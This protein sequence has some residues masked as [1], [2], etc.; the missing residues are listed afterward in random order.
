M[1]ET[2]DLPTA[3]ES[4][5]VE[6]RW[7]EHWEK[8][9]Y[10]HAE[11]TS[12][13]PPFCI[14]IPPPNVTGSLHIGHALTVAV[15]DLLIRWKRM[16]GFNTL[17]MPGTDHAGIATQMVVERELLKT[18]KKSRQDLGREAFVERV[19]K[20]KAQYG[21]RITTQLRALGCSVDWPRERFTMDEGLSRAVREVFVQL[22]EQG[23]LYRA[24]RL[25]NWCP[26]DG[27]ALSDLEVEHEEQNGSLWHIAYPVEGTDRKLVV[28]T[29]RP[30]TMLGDTA[31][32]VHPDDPRYKDLIGKRVSLPLTDRKI[33][34]IADPILVDMNFGSGAV[35]VTPAHDPNDYETGLRHH[36][37]MISVLDER[38]HI[39][40]NGY[41]YKGLDRFKARDQI[42]ADLTAQ[43]LLEKVEPHKL[44]V[45]T[46][47]RCG[48]VIEP[49]LLGF[50]W[51]VKIKPLADK[52]IEAVE[53]GETN[54]VPEFWKNTFFAWM[55]NIHD[56]C[57]SRQIWWGH[58]I[59]AWYCPDGH[60]T[61][62]REEPKACKECGKSE[63][64]RDTDVLDT[65]FSSGLWPFSTLGW[66]DDTP[67]LR[68]F[69]PNSVM[70]T[71]HDII[72]FWV[73][74]MMM[75]GIHF[76]GKVPFKTVYLHAM[77]RDEK[78]DKMSKVK[79]NVVDPLDVIHGQK[80]ENLPPAI[81]KHYADKKQYPD[82]MP[83]YGADALRFTLVALTAQGRD[84]K[85]SLKQVEGYKAFANKI[86][87][88][89]RFALLNLGGYKPDGKA[90]HDRPLS[91]ADRW[92]LSR[93]ERA[94]EETLAALE[95]YKFN[96][97]ASKL[98]SFTWY[99]LCDWYIELS[100][101]A[102]SG[103]DQEARAAAQAVLVHC[104][105][106]TMKLLHPIMPYVTEEIWQKL[107]KPA[108]SP[109]S[110]MIAPYPKPDSRLTDRAAE[111]D[112]E[113][114]M[115]TIDGLRNIRGESNIAPAK[116]LRAVIYA[117]DH[118]RLARLQRHKSYVVSLAGLEEI[119]LSS[120]GVKPPKSAAYVGS[121]LEI[122]VPLEGLIDLAEEQK[123]LEKEIEK[124]DDDLNKLKT[125]H[126]NPNF[127]QRAPPE[128]IEKDRARIA[129]LGE[130]RSKLQANLQQLAGAST[131]APNATEVKMTT[132]KDGS[133][134][135][136]GQVSI[137]KPETPAPGEAVDLG[138]E[139]SAHVGDV[140]IPE[141]PKQVM[142]SLDKL[143]EGT[144]EGLS[145]QDHK[146]LGVAYMQM[147]LIDDAVREF[148]T[149]S[150]KADEE[151]VNLKS[152]TRPGN[153]P[154]AKGAK[155]P[156]SSA[157]TSKPKKSSAPK[158]AKSAKSSKST[159]PKSSKSA[160]GKKAPKAKAKSRASKP[161]KKKAG[162][163]R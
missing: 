10:F 161:V 132:N 114:V 63:L 147:G 159:K 11:D 152:S 146:D 80:L 98:H 74:R 48:T 101:G 144:K 136:E 79:G 130:K 13:K 25:I 39:N 103:S 163:K 22:Y 29:T 145:S 38:A 17:W 115:A 19:W 4:Q 73:A 68:T 88:A 83:A 9:G 61:V 85:L 76:M 123:R 120:S 46:C 124:V 69:Y 122:Y 53:R 153:T 52:A 50:Q 3:Y 116:K 14:V 151:T 30:E 28:A 45:G 82:G 60:V 140:A 135:G 8:A 27:T 158:S 118:E 77:V 70:E 36:L 84:I 66:P 16:S 104:L 2:I 97:A 72:F 35:K 110:I 44:A 113:P 157:R 150:A 49:M 138:K 99:E 107:P 81:Q 134:L 24:K 89:S 119:S 127:I 1:T 137:A 31:V 91:L 129:E 86:W 21:S 67:A 43:G 125:K 71:G 149:S 87:N 7:Y 42:V 12:D 154:A 20:W 37:E 5:N 40:E 156:A 94:V 128:V 18:E 47:Q 105:D 78:G 34:I 55:S 59:P 58:Q 32:A 108:G 141:P 57:V 109:A 100:K 26:R 102:L 96:E 75:F 155:K 162:K 56:W 64:K 112:M 121:G 131:S 139:L 148:K 90:L 62:A 142:D 92:I 33:P 15:E 95:A 111:A 51:F 54:F 133:L 93:L 160:K 41:A 106:Q 6:R 117:A 65:W 23:L 143:R 126:A